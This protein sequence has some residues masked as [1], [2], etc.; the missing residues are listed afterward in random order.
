MEFSSPSREECPK[1][2]GRVSI[3]AGSL[4][5][6]LLLQAVSWASGA[7][8]RY[9]SRSSGHRMELSTGPYRL[10]AP[11]QES[12]ITSSGYPWPAVTSPSAPT[13]MQTPLM[14]S[15]CTTSASQRKIPSSRFLDAYAEHKLQFWAVTAENEPSAGLLSGYAF[16][17]LGFTPEHQRDFIA[18]DLGPTLA[19]STHHN[20]RL[21]MLDDQRLLLPHWAKVVLTDPEAAKGL[22]GFQVLGAECAARLLGSRDAVQ[23]QHHHKPPVPCGRL[24]RLEPIIVDITKHTFYK[25]PMFYHLG[26]FS[27]FIP[28]GS[29]RVGLVASQKNDLDTVALMHP[30]GSAV[31]VVLN[32]SPKDVPL[33]IKDPA[34]GFLE[35][36]SPGYS[37]HTYLWRRQ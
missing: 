9:K 22:C 34:V 16:Q 29:Q 8:S 35:T 2:S 12:D 5:G 11:A 18:R 6:L 19:N 24:D 26:H 15:S 28:E 14:I 3:M 1:P 13:P 10:I 27:K 17:C 20:V 25:Q 36:I 32:R 23:P 30:D 21:L 33:T 31:V 37:I 7:F 4:T